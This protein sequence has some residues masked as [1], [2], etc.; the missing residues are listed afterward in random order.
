RDIYTPA[1]SAGKHVCRAG[2]AGRQVGS[3]RVS[4]VR[5]GR[6]TR[7]IA[8]DSARAVL[9]PQGSEIVAAATRTLVGSGPKRRALEVKDVAT[10][11]ESSASH[12]KELVE[13]NTELNPKM[14]FAS[15]YMIREMIAG[16]A[17]LKAVVRECR[18]GQL[19]TLE[20][21]E[22]TGIPGL[23]QLDP[24]DT[25]IARVDVN[26]QDHI[27]RIHYRVINEDH[28]PWST[29]ALVLVGIVLPILTGA[30]VYMV[31]KRQPR[32]QVQSRP[33][34]EEAQESPA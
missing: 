24:K 1:G 27:I 20:L 28:V 3:N 16:I 33:Y 26:K 29:V 23:A 13:T 11:S 12:Q 2:I 7:V 22:L 6:L 10:V 34:Q 14:L 17:N 31:T 8:R 4:P 15:Y 21:A 19:A 30:G 32:T 9:S 18:K 25:K 5:C